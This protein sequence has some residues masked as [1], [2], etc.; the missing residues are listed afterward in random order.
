MKVKLGH[1]G[2]QAQISRTANDV[3]GYGAKL[4]S[5]ARS[6][7]QSALHQIQEVAS[8]T[9]ESIFPSKRTLLGLGIITQ[10][11]RNR[12][13]DNVRSIKLTRRNVSDDFVDAI[14]SGLE[15]RLAHSEQLK[16]AL[17]EPLRAEI[18][19]LRRLPEE[20]S[21]GLGLFTT[22]G[23]I[24]AVGYGINYLFSR[25]SGEQIPGMSG[26]RR[27]QTRERGESR[28]SGRLEHD[29]PRTYPPT[30]HTSGSEMP[31]TGEKMSSTSGDMVTGQTSIENKPEDYDEQS[32]L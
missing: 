25:Y 27:H 13:E 20:K 6:V 1:N 2:M 18:P 19:R 14:A 9:K 30:V 7:G 31:E 21:S 3:L 4:G 5:G 10:L 26:S 24:V 16:R 8:K 32:N 22:L 28:M 15:K 23:L 11:L 17:V 29:R 12:E